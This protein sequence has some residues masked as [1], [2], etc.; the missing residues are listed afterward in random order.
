MSFF[1]SIRQKAD[2]AALEADKLLR[3]RREQAGITQSQ[4]DLKSQQEALGE[5]TFEAY[6]AGRIVD[7]QLITICQRI[8]ATLIAIQQ[9]EAR[10][11]GIR[12]EQLLPQGDL[13]SCTGCHAQI[14]ARA[15]FCPHCGTRVV[16]PVAATVTC[17]R[18]GGAAPAGSAFCPACGNP[19]TPSTSSPRC[20]ACGAEI[21][22]GV[23][24]CPECGARTTPSKP[25][26]PPVFAGEVESP[27]PVQTL[28]TAPTEDV[29]VSETM[30]WVESADTAADELPAMV[31][32]N[33]AVSS[34]LPASR[35]AEVPERLD[36]VTSAAPTTCQA[37]GAELPQASVFCPDCG[38]RVADVR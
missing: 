11:E 13:V 31:P 18:C 1:T 34:G 3:I 26:T 32:T 7:P 30:P 24:Y 9:A 36:D 25:T 15:L 21:P 19:M 12:G 20:T 29:E 33:E 17:P 5:A 22:G 10:I 6:R 37:C 8:E 23:G 38:A 14:P 27:S 35:V 4:R 28:P 16:K 2:G